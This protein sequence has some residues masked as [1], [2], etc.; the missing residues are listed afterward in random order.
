[1]ELINGDIPVVT[2]DHVFD[3]RISILSDNIKGMK[4]LL[5]HI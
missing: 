2:I 5:T 1:M 4:D 3:N